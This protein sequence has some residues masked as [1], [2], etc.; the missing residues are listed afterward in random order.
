[1]SYYNKNWL[2]DEYC[3]LFKEKTGSNIDDAEKVFMKNY[4]SVDN[5]SSIKDIYYLAV[6]RLKRGYPR[7]LVYFFVTMSL[8]SDFCKKNA[9]DSIQKLYKSFAGAG[10]YIVLAAG[11]L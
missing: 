1:M 3:S 9:P 6:Y 2:Y 4:F 11:N 10:R 8:K 5:D 7:W